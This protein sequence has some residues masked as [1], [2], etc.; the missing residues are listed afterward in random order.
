MEAPHL[1]QRLVDDLAG[2]LGEPDGHLG[3]LLDGEFRGVADVHRP[4]L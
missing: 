4:N 1:R 2:G 3:E